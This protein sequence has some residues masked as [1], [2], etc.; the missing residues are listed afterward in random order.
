MSE[1]ALVELLVIEWLSGYGTPAPGTPTASAGSIATRLE[2]RLDF[3]SLN[4]SN[5]ASVA[6][7]VDGRDHF[8]ED[9]RNYSEA[10]LER[11]DVLRRAGW[12][13][14]HVP[15]YRWWRNGWLNDRHD[16]HFQE[17]INQL[18]AELRGCLGLA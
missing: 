3:V 13:I 12:E 18:F 11:V 6:V 16:P 7:E 9:G 14:V 4:G 2:K 15:Y 1:S 17:T 10:H 5:G 8:T